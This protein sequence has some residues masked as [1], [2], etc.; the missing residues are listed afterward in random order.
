MMELVQG[1]G[2]NGEIT[3]KGGPSGDRK[4]GTRDYSIL[5]FQEK[6]PD[7]LL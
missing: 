4:I 7:F 2:K 1:R 5:G 3:D 6:R